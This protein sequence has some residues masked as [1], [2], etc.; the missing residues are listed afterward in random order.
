ML[1]ASVLAHFIGVGRL[2]VIDAGGRRHVFEGLPG[3]SATIRLRDPTL[4]WKLLLKP[5]L[6]V[7]EA[8]MDGRL[9]G[10]EGSLY[11][12]IDILVSN[13]AAQATA[14]LRLGQGRGA[15]GGSLAPVKSGPAG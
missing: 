7:G 4:H 12:F 3:P 10:E 2:S 11:D 8:Y 15:P 14:L 1:F 13:D 6:F 9:T 5:R